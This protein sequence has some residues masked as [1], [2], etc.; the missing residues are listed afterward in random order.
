LVDAALEPIANKFG[1]S[2]YLSE[3]INRSKFGVDWFSNF[4]SGKV[5]NLMFVIGTKSGPY[6]CS[7][8]ALARDN[9]IPNTLMII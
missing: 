3:L 4:G 7:A 5:H 6:H 2:L 1:N 9:R 8:T